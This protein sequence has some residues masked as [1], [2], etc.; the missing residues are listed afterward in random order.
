MVLVAGMHTASL[1]AFLTGGVLAG[2]GAGV[3]FKAAVGTVSAMSA[4]ARRGE[5]L[6]GLFLIAYLGLTL[7]VVGVGLAT[8]SL[9]ATTVMTWFAGLLL[10][11]LTGVA[12]LARR[13][14][15]A[16]HAA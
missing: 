1:A 11:L 8:L 4:P 5:A 7:P 13:R 6:A 9:A 12:V 2:A 14:S 3:L 10:V 15:H 16:P